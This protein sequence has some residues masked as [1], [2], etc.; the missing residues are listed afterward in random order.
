MRERRAEL[1]ERNERATATWE[2]AD[3]RTFN[4]T[5]QPMEAGWLATFEDISARCAAEARMVHLAHHDALTDL[6]NRVLFH[7]KLRRRW[8]LRAAATSSPCY[9]SILIN[10]RLSMTRSDIRLAMPCC[11]QSQNG[12]AAAHAKPT[13]WRAWAADEYAIIQTAIAKPA[14]ATAFATRLLHLLSAP[15]EVAGH[16]IIIGASIGIAFA[17]EDGFDADQLLRCADLALSRAKLDGRGVYRLFQAEMDAQMQQRRLL[18][19]DL[20]QAL[21]GRPV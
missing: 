8:R 7:A 15:F 6:P 12:F 2:L 1:L 17:P 18:E 5:H 16:H 19:L 11:R 4:V 3:G 20:R 13:Q 10:S 9:A 14:E 21:R